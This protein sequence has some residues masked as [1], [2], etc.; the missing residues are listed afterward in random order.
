MHRGWCFEADKMWC[1][2]CSLDADFR[3][4]FLL[5]KQLWT[6]ERDRERGE[7]GRGIFLTS[8]GSTGDICCYTSSLM[9]IHIF[10]TLRE[11][12]E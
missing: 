7:G 6:R 9:C 2:L 10:N 5:G 3:A 8:T 4:P 1:R 11:I 12:K